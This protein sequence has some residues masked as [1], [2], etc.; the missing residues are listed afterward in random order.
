M[1]LKKVSRNSKL[2][3]IS[4]IGD[5]AH[6]EEAG[7]IPDAVGVLGVVGRGVLQTGDV[8]AHLPD[9]HVADAQAPGRNRLQ[10]MALLQLRGTSSCSISLLRPYQP[11]VAQS[12][13]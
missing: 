7:F 10:N 1:S 6:L 13:Q 12:D 9:T 2:L 4:D 8:P 5:C 3:T 11:M